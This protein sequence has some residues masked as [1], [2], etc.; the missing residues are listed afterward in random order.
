MRFDYSPFYRYALPYAKAQ[1]VAEETLAIWCSLASRLGL[2]AL[3]AELEDL[4]FA[5]LQVRQILCYW[6]SNDSVKGVATPRCFV[7]PTLAS[8]SCSYIL[9]A[10]QNFSPTSGWPGFYVELHEQGKQPEKNICKAQCHQTI[11]WIW[12]NSWRGGG[13][14]EHEGKSIMTYL[15]V[16]FCSNRLAIISK[17]SN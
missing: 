6:E 14:L 12:R 16:C 13:K 7:E 10:A 17:S 1:A 2:W 3:K 11:S 9:L 15:L 4:C 8:N 5:V